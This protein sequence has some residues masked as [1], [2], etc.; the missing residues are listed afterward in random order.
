MIQKA[1]R[2]IS[3]LLV[4]MMIVSL[5]TIVPISASAAEE[6]SITGSAEKALR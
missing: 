2:P 4:I 6:D 3:I 5:F 1:K